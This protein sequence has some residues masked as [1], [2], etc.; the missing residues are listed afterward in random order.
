MC[1]ISS[2]IFGAANLSRH[3]IENKRVIEI[4]SYNINGS[5]RAFI[6]SRRPFEY[7]GVDIVAGP[8]VDIICPAQ[9]IL[10]K[11]GSASF[12][13]VVATE[14]IEHVL[15]WR[16]VISNIKNICKT[17]GVI[18]VTTRSLGFKYHGFPYDFWRYETE[19]MQELFSDCAIEKMERDCLE[20][21]VCIKARKPSGFI[22]RNLSEHALYSIIVGRRVLTIDA[23]RIEDFHKNY[24]RQAMLRKK[25]HRFIDRLMPFKF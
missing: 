23:K 5:L 11:F 24:A 17:N 2:I 13:I 9:D 15:D 22:E 16:L 3:E 12:D 10:S 14:L 7:I 8:G 4:G 6:E 25:I 20:P 19:D 18:I 1:N 21:G